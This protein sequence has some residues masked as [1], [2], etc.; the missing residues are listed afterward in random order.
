MAS[1][2]KERKQRSAEIRRAA[3]ELRGVRLELAQAENCF[4][5]MIDPNQLDACIFEINAL[6]ARYNCAVHDLKRSTAP[7]S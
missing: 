1:K 6:R 3:E 5:H 4:N 7:P 2:R